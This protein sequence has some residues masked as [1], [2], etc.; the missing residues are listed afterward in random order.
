MKPLYLAYLLPV[1][2]TE[3]SLWSYGRS[4]KDEK[5]PKQWLAFRKELG[6]SLP[7]GKA[8]SFGSGLFW[9]PEELPENRY[10]IFGRDGGTR[11]AEKYG[12]PLLGQIPIVQSIREGGD[13]GEPAALGSRPD[14][15]AFLELARKLADSV[16]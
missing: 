14:G 10:Y 15:M 11:M 7:E 8:I 9:A 3:G 4:A 2:C 1:I 5:L 6:I 13:D 12:I 16:R